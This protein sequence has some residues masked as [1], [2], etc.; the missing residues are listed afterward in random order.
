MRSLLLLAP[1]ALVASAAAQAAPVNYFDLWSGCTNFTSRGAGGVNECDILQQ[2]P[3]V[4]YAGIGHVAGGTGTTLNGFRYVMQD[5]NAATIEN[6][7]MII[8]S[9]AAGAPDVT[10]TGVLLETAPIA[11]P[12]GSGILAW[13]ITLTLATA[14]T[15]VPQCATFYHGAHVPANAGWTATDALSYHICTYF[16]TNGVSRADN[17]AT[18]Y[19][20]N[21]AWNVVRPANLVTQ[22]GAPRNIRFELAVP[23]AVAT[24]GNVDP[25]LVSDT[26]W[27]VN[28]S[29]NANRSWGAGGMYPMVG[30][31]RNDGLDIRVRDLANAGGFAVVFLGVDLG[32]CPGIP[33]TG[34]ANGSL[35]LNPGALTQIGVGALSPTGE[36]I[37]TILPPGA[38]NSTFA[39]AVIDF[40]A[41]TLS[42]T[43]ALPGSLSNRATVKYFR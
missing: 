42:P 19:T 1:L 23:S 3:S 28:C 34:L 12:G 38:A 33:L 20:G 21:L 13:Q 35:Y 10:P 4:N 22:P 8:R 11:S 37:Q 25:T 41:F 27:Q 16:V 18:T 29:A 31:S 6:Y 14:S 36:S 5:Q 26:F 7:S 32:I 2:V 43:L 40:Q 17:P 15:V 9:D 30:G 24:L 39:N